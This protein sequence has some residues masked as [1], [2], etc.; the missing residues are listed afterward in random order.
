[1]AFKD[2]APF[3]GTALTSANR[4]QHLGEWRLL[5]G[6]MQTS[7]FNTNAALLPLTAANFR[8]RQAQAL[9]APDVVPIATLLTR[10]DRFTDDAGTAGLITVG[11]GQLYDAPNRPR[12]PYEQRTLVAL[13]PLTSQSSTRTLQFLLPAQLLFANAAPTITTLEFDAG[14]GQGYRPAAWDQPLSVTYAGNGSYTLRFRLTCADGSVL[15]S[16]ARFD[17]NQPPA[18]RY[19]ADDPRFPNPNV[20]T[21]PTN[22]LFTDARAYN[23]PNG[24]FAATGRV[25]VALAD[26]NTTGTIRKPLIVIEGYDPSG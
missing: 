26:N 18:S 1:M 10:Y 24:F 22:A 11:N 17:V 4:L 25:T 20:V 7:I 13:C 15:L 3:Q 19:G 5:Y 14:E 6:A 8:I 9:A 12:V 23:S 2:C 16:Q 21:R